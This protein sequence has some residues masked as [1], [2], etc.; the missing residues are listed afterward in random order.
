M[1]GAN[2]FIMFTHFLMV[3]SFLPTGLVKVFDQR[4]TAMPDSNF[5]GHLLKNSTIKCYIFMN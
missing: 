4:F 3:L 2:Y 1:I 5:V